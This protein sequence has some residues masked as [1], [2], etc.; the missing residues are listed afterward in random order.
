MSTK[1][2]HHKITSTQCVRDVVV[3]NIEN[4]GGKCLCYQIRKYYCILVK[5]HWSSI[6]WSCIL[7]Q[8]IGYWHMGGKRSATNWVYDNDIFA[9]I[10]HHWPRKSFNIF[11]WFQILTKN[12]IKQD[13]DKCIFSNTGNSDVLIE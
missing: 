4:G 12:M 7:K 10:W 2:W 9:V 5:D 8:N 13:D 3:S 6:G 1:P 11:L